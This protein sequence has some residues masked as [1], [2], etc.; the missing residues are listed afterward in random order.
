[1]TTA[2]DFIIIMSHHNWVLHVVY[3]SVTGFEQPTQLSFALTYLA[4]RF[5]SKFKQPP[6]IELWS[7][8]I[9]LDPNENSHRDPN[10]ALLSCIVS[11]PNWNS[12]ISQNDT[13][14]PMQP[15]V[16][17]ILQSLK[18]NSALRFI[19]ASISFCYLGTEWH[20]DVSK[21]GGSSE[22]FLRIEN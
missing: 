10:W 4:Y 12:H 14:R 18:F 6:Q 5:R 17:R 22:N 15:A 20:C 13:C 1:M 9:I 11:S 8:C 19:S 21:T 16:P 7:L 2:S 3:R